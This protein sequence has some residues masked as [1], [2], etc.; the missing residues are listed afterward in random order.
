MPVFAVNGLATIRSIVSFQFPPHT[1]T[2][3][4]P[5]ANDAT[6]VIRMIA[7]ASH[8]T[9]DR[10]TMRASLIG[11]ASVSGNSRTP[12]VARNQRLAEHH[13]NARPV[14]DDLAQNIRRN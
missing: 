10:R 4:G 9:R 8:V 14:F 7:S 3:S 2:T 5:W 1:L 6:G 13:G 11:G 12:R